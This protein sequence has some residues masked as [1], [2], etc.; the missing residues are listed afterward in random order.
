ML[1]AIHSLLLGG[2][3]LHHQHLFNLLNVDIVTD[4]HVNCQR[5]LLY[6]ANINT[7]L[8]VEQDC[9]CGPVGINAHVR[10]LV[11]SAMEI[12]RSIK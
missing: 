9:V 2:G 11:L 4:W 3:H 8:V 5:L 10:L 12:Y 1:S 7:A 6:I